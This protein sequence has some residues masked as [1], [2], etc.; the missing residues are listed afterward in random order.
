MN[1]PSPF[2]KVVADAKKELLKKLKEKWDMD[3]SI[4]IRVRRL[5]KNNWLALYRSRTQFGNRG[6]IFWINEDF[7]DICTREGACSKQQIL[8]TIFH[9][10]GHVIDEWGMLRDHSLGARINEVWLDAEEFAEDFAHY[11]YDG[12]GAAA[13]DEVVQMYANSAFGAEE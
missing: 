5:K 8:L 10:Y 6:P 12:W 11:L 1:K 9:E 4:T 13:M 3:E 2:L 7:E